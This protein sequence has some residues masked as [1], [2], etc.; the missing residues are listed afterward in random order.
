M[1]SKFNQQCQFCDKCFSTKEY[2]ISH[3]KRRH[4]HDLSDDESPKIL[5]IPNVTVK[6]EQ[7][8]HQKEQLDE[9]KSLS[10]M[11]KE[12]KTSFEK[13]N[14]TRLHQERLKFEKE[15]QDI[16]SNMQ[17]KMEEEITKLKIERESFEH[18]IV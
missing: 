5:H 11:V 4:E 16:K 1:Y 2:R 13:E 6:P 17:I 15:I 10:A 9:I 7:I 12:L 8:E 18:L 14:E 3:E